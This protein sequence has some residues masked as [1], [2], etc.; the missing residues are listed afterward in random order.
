MVFFACNGHVNYIHIASC[1]GFPLIILSFAIFRDHGNNSGLTSWKPYG[2]PL[3]AQVSRNETICGY[4]IHERVHKMLMPMLRNQDSQY[5]AI[6][7][8]VSTRTQNYHTDDDSKFELYL[9]DDSNT[10]IE[11]SNDAIRVPQSSLAAVFFINWSKAGLKKIDTNHLENL[12]EVFKFAPPAKRTRGEPL[13]LY[14]C[15]DAFLRE[16]PLVPEEMWL[17]YS[18]LIPRYICFLKITIISWLHL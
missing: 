18:F 1:I 11:K 13:S 9:L 17:V 7:S 15:L 16:E 4:D 8:S 6:Q 14:A 3:L 5:S 2:V 12:P 10:I